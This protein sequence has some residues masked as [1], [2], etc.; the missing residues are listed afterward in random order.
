MILMAQ[1]F[2]VPPPNINVVKVCLAEDHSAAASVNQ[3]SLDPLEALE[4]TAHIYRADYAL[5]SHR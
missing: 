2:Y 5:T 4:A 1:M 3:R